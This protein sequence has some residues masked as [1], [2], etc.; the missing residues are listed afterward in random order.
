LAPEVWGRLRHAAKREVLG[1]N[2]R[3]ALAAGGGATRG[4]LVMLVGGCASDP[5]VPDIVASELEREDVAVARANVLG[6]HGPR[7][8]VAVGLV[9]TFVAGGAR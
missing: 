5:E 2:V 6:R 1:L 4:E 9:L 3:R 8:A 7:A